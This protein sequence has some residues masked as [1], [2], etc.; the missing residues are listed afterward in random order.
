MELAKSRTPAPLSSPEKREQGQRGV[1]ARRGLGGFIAPLYGLTVSTGLGST[2]TESLGLQELK[3]KGGRKRNSCLDKHKVE[4]VIGRGIWAPRTFSNHKFSIAVLKPGNLSWLL[5]IYYLRSRQGQ[6]LASSPI[7]TLSS[8]QHLH[9]LE[10]APVPGCWGGFGTCL[11]CDCGRPA[12]PRE[13]RGMRS[14]RVQYSLCLLEERC[15]NQKSFFLFFKP[16]EV[17]V[18]IQCAK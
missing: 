12:Q 7:P 3:T 1:E 9:T 6:F 2:R 8:L 5:E 11:G 14:L 15:L 13:A 10:H 16:E 18:I 4:K 17:A